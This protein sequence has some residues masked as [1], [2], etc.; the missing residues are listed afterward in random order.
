M[1]NALKRRVQGLAR[2]LLGRM[3]GRTDWPTEA[4][5]RASGGAALAAKGKKRRGERIRV[6]FVCHMPALWPTFDSIYKAAIDD[7]SFEVTVVALP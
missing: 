1:K 5:R 7:P 3:M 4:T 2:S 6:L